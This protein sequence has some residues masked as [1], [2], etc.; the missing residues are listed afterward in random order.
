L[1]NPGKI[2]PES[3]SAGSKQS[4]L[5]DSFQPQA[6]NKSSFQALLHGDI[7]DECSPIYKET[8]VS[9]ANG[10]SAGGTKDFRPGLGK[11]SA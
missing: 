7:K 6:S 1:A 3:P 9:Y 8:R 11:I 4:F 5:P 10:G 2:S